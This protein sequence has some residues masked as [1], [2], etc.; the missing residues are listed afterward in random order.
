MGRRSTEYFAAFGGPSIRLTQMP[1]RQMPPAGD[2]DPL[3]ISVWI[4]AC[5]GMTKKKTRCPIL[6]TPP[7][8]TSA[9]ISGGDMIGRVFSRTVPG[10]L[11]AM[12]ALLA[13]LLLSSDPATNYGD[14]CNNPR[15]A[16]RWRPTA[17]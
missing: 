17:T 12:L 1:R 7:R 9:A 3:I 14:T 10:R 11:G 5:L 6:D 4:P 2:A 16:G 15:I 13:A 8:R